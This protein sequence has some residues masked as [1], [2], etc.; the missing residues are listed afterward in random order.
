M[1]NLVELWL[2]TTVRVLVL[3]GMLIIYLLLSAVV[4]I[5]RLHFASTDDSDVSPEIAKASIQRIQKH[6]YRI[7]QATYAVFFLFGIVLFLVLQ[8]V[9]VTI[10]DGNPGWAA[11]QILRNFTF[12]C[13]F[14]ANVFC[15]FLVLHVLQWFI[16]SRINTSLETLASVRLRQT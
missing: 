11:N 5:A 4:T 1:V 7:G 12:S 15:G 8:R 13:A 10:G 6:W 14:A 2:A 3:V 9:G 16:S